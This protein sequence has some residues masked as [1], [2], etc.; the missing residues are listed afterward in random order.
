V[1]KEQPSRSRDDRIREREAVLFARYEASAQERAVELPASAV[2][3]RVLSA[4]RGPDLVLLHDVNLCAASW[5]PL[6][7]FLSGYRVHLVDLPGHGLS[8]PTAYRPGTVREQTLRLIDGLLDALDVP[9]APVIGHSLGAM[10]ALWHAAARPGRITAIAAI[11]S[12]SGALP[13]V[14]VRMPLSLLT[15]PVL[16]TA[17][18][19]SSAP[20]P[21]YRWLLSM[22]LGADAEAA[23]SPEL[24]DVLRLSSARPGNGRTVAWLVRALNGPRRPR[25]ETVMSEAELQAVGAPVLFCWGS[26]DAYQSPDQATA[27]V[28]AMPSA[29]LRT[30]PG[31]HG[32]WLG[33]PALCAGLA[34]EHLVASGCPPAA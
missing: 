24:L 29:E 10:Y 26:E 14:R 5:A 6:L 7:P 31:G 25:D 19:R 21:L 20:R 28:K 9:A 12:P 2:S 30:V 15:V 33:D 17:V 11:G 27:S 8:D 34:V 13:G 1:Q 22:G 32:C 23:V 4:G 18:L 3:L 16:G